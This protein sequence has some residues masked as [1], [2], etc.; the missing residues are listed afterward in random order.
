M[1]EERRENATNDETR[2]SRQVAAQAKRKLRA[3]RGS[4]K[5]VWFGLGM[6]GL[7]GWSVTVPTLIGTALGIWVDRH[8]PSKFSWT[9]M[10]LLF[11]LIIGCCNAW[12]WVASEYKE[13][14]EDPDE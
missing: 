8:Y 14:Q 2:F 13:M 7:I 6:S 1:D 12:H 9:L 3:K 5:S 4:A 10:L 11:G